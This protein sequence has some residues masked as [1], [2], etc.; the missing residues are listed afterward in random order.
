[1]FNKEGWL[2]GHLTKE[3]ARTAYLISLQETLLKPDEVWL[4]GDMLNQYVFIKYYSDEIM[5]AI[6]E[7]KEGE[8]S[9][10]T[11]FLVN[12]TT[13]SK[14]KLKR[15]KHKYQYRWGMLIKRPGQ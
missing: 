1:M 9:L 10:T 14:V 3:E 2:A 7:V 11:W 12:E 15:K 5:A 13:G 8:V 4:N 6:V